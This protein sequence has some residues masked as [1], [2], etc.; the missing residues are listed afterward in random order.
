MCNRPE[1]CSLAVEIS[2]VGVC[3]HGCEN[4]VDKSSQ[5]NIA[6]MMLSCPAGMGGVFKPSRGE[7]P[8]S[9]LCI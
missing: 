3:E 2:A 5:V 4:M 8:L 7:L 6:V 1:L 9:V